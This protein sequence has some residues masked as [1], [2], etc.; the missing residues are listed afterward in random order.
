MKKPLEAETWKFGTEWIIE[1]KHCREN[2]TV[3]CLFLERRWNISSCAKGKKDNGMIKRKN[4]LRSH[5][6][7]M[8]TKYVVKN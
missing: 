8:K 5:L 1:G 6:F 2:G 4:I 7:I 3:N